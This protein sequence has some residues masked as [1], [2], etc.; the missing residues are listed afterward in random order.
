MNLKTAKVENTAAVCQL[1]RALQAGESGS[2]LVNERDRDLKRV[3]PGQNPCDLHLPNSFHGLQEQRRIG[4]GIEGIEAAAVDQ[5][6]TEQISAIR[7]IITA[8]TG[9]MPG[10]VDREQ[11][12]PAEIQPVSIV[13][14]TLGTALIEPVLFD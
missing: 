1:S 4:R 6:S 13:Q 9:G 5:I 11:T 14:E 10:S 12:A 8:L 7:F 2:D 3:V